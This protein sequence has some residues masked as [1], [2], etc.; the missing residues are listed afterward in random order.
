MLIKIYPQNPNPREIEKVVKILRDGGIVIYPTDTVYGL[1]C[2]INNTKA[3]ERICRIKGINPR[4]DHLSIICHD[5]SHL[6]DY[7]K[8]LSNTIFKLIRKNL[9][10]PFTFILPAS[11]NVPRFFKSNK[12]TIGLRI[13]DNAIIREIVR[14][15]G[16]P[17]L[18]T[19]IKDDDDVLEYTTDPELIHEK[20]QDLVDAVIDGGYG[21]NIASTVVDCTNTA[22]Y[23]IIRKGKKELE[24]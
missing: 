8:P 16:N 10:G 11:N 1:G 3:L 24:F 5:L 18:S 9:P 4:K 14:Q 2:D 15:L 23:Q 6:S 20:Y 7:T 21:G 17:I 19:S 12:K 22:E 13:P